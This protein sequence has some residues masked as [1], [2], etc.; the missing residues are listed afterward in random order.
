LIRAGRTD[1]GVKELREV[2]AR[3]PQNETA[4]RALAA[5]GR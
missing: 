4:R 5:I 1:D 3:D 2:L